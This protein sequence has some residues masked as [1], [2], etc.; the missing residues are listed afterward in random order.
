M[1]HDQ[2]NINHLEH[3][4]QSGFF[5]D[6][7]LRSVPVKILLVLIYS[8]L[9]LTGKPVTAIFC[10]TVTGNSKLPIL[11]SVSPPLLELEKDIIF[12]C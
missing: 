1:I 6:S 9:N 4:A 8:M 11:F 5:V 12:E 7:I 3:S 2:Q 10:K